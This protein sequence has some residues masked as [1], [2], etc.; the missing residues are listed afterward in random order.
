MSL[1]SLALHTATL[2]AEAEGEAAINPYLV[3][4]IALL[5]L[6]AMLLALIMFGAGREH[7]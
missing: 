5:I 2:A 7:S 1:T 3:G 6:L 4:G